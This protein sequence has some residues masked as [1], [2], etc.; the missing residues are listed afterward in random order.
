M[1]LLS[2]GSG[3]DNLYYHHLHLKR[4]FKFKDRFTIMFNWH[5]IV[6]VHGGHVWNYQ[7]ASSIFGVVDTIKLNDFIE[8]F[9][10][11]CDMQ[12]MDNL[13]LF[14]FFIAWKALF[15]HLKKTPM[16]D[17]HEFRCA[18]KVIYVICDMCK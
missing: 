14:T 10:M 15:Q 18:I 2:G 3:L 17:C 1:S 11:C 5:I 12:W 6:V 4:F 16:N 13:Q 7:G 9:D 8:N